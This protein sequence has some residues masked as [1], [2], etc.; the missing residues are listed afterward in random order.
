MDDKKIKMTLVLVK[1]ALKNVE[2][3]INLRRQGKGT[4]GN[5]AQ[6]ETIR[7]V[8]FKILSQIDSGNIP[9]RSMRQSGMGRFIIDSWPIDSK[10]G[11]LIIKAEQAYKNL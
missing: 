11:E 9:P 3:E 4:V 1:L 2:D 10:L 8:L 5:L 7:D 6:L